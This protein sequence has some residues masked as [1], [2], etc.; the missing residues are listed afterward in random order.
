MCTMF[1]IPCGSFVLLSLLG[2][3]VNFMFLANQPFLNDEE[4]GPSEVL[5]LDWTFACFIPY[6]VAIIITVAGLTRILII[7][8]IRKIKTYFKIKKKS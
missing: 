2:V 6:A 1:S 3:I 4:K 5:F 8:P 7:K